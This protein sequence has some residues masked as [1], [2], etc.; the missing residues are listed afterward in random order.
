MVQTKIAQKTPTLKPNPPTNVPAIM[1]K[2][3][4]PP[5]W[6]LSNLEK[7]KTLIKMRNAEAK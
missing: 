1:K 7:D 5:S 6:Y 2:I 4:T 3:I